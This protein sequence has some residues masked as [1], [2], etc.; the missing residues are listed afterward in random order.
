MF[1]AAAVPS[2]AEGVSLPPSL[3]R[4]VTLEPPFSFS[5]PIETVRAA[6]V[7]IAAWAA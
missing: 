2:E 6:E 7:E 3:T 1:S 4:E 5:S